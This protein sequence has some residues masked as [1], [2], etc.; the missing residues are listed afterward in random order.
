MSHL[1]GFISWGDIIVVIYQK[2]VIFCKYWKPVKRLPVKK[3]LSI[4]HRL[5]I[6]QINVED[7]IF[8]KISTCSSYQPQLK[9]Y[10]ILLQPR[11]PRNL[12]KPWLARKVHAKLYS[13][14]LFCSIITTQLLSTSL[15]SE[16]QFWPVSELGIFHTLALNFKA[17]F[18][19]MRLTIFKRI[20][21]SHLWD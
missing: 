10:Y 20:N 2:C 13:I 6:K 5:R 12:L 14:F 21:C 4:L 9:A 1:S 17:W 16:L 11:N 3:L 18:P 15:K 19:P 7:Y 8:K